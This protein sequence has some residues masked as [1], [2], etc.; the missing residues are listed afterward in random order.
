MKSEYLVCIR[1]GREI[2]LPYNVQIRTSIRPIPPHN[3]I[4]ILRL[5]SDLSCK[6][7]ELFQVPFPSTPEHVVCHILGWI[8]SI[9][10][11]VSEKNLIPIT[12]CPILMFGSPTCSDST[13]SW[14]QR[15]THIPLT[16]MR[17]EKLHETYFRLYYSTP[18]IM[19]KKQIV[20]LAE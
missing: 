8:E 2:A 11:F 7:V 14:C 10:E 6:N 9:C 20:F 17:R 13:M 4:N 16:N 1:V 18:S 15:N 5:Y 3:I 12:L 19:L